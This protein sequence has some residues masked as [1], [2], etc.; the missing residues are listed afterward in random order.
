MGKCPTKIVAVNSYDKILSWKK[1]MALLGPYSPLE[2]L[3][4]FLLNLN[5]NKKLIH[6]YKLSVKHW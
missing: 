1:G 5:L 3:S 4:K 6:D 2:F